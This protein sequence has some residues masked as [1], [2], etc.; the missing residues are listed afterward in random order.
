MRGKRAR[1]IRKL[2]NTKL[3]VKADL[4]VLKEVEKI[5]YFPNKVT[6]EMEMVKAKR[7]TVLNAAKYHYKSAKKRLKK[8]LRIPDIEKNGGTV[9]TETE[10]VTEFN[11]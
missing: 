8:G 1:L 5:V 9:T 3:P 7:T 11:E 10:E 4:R 2:T 6:G